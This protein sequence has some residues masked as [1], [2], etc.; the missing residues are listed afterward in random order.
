MWKHSTPRGFN[1]GL[2]NSIGGGRNPQRLCPPS[3][4]TV[5]IACDMAVCQDET[6]FGYYESGSP[7]YL[8]VFPSLLVSAMW[9]EEAFEQIVTKHVSEVIKYVAT[10]L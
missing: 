10:C 7:P 9:R 6:V 2:E 4:Q 3:R 8:F 1:D 5:C